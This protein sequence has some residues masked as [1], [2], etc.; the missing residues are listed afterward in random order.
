MSSK[1]RNT[2][3]L[4]KN[5]KSNKKINGQKTGCLKKKKLPI[6]RNENIPKENFSVLFQRTY[7]ENFREDKFRK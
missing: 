5:D 7:N 1:Y 4:K 2:N 6:F 3:T